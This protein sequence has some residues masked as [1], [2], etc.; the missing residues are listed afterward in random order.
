MEMGTGAGTGR[1][2][3]GRLVGSRRDLGDGKVMLY[4]VFI[5]S[6]A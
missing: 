1:G 6:L 3:L 4:F 2:M 5:H